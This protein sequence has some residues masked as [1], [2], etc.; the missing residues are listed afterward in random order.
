[1]QTAFKPYLL[2]LAA[3]LAG[4]LVLV[5]AYVALLPMAY[6]ESGYPAWVAKSQMLQQ[7]QLGDVAFFGDLRL[8]AGLIPAELPVP[9]SNFGLAAGTAVEA[10]TAVARAMACADKPKQAVISLSPGHFGPL[11]RFFWLLSLRYGFIGPADLWATENLASQLG[12]DQILRHPDAGR[13]LRPAARLAVRSSASPRSPSATWCRAASSAATTATR[14]GWRPC[15]RRAAGRNTPK[16]APSRTTNRNTSPPSCNPP[17]W[18][19][20]SPCCS[21]TAST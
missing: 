12:D 9:A 15:C 5:W 3:A 20:P 1:M 7:C 11:S 13:P 6:M 2:R 10:H 4:I 18:K 21:S 19:R 16:A 8:E 14:P 17:S